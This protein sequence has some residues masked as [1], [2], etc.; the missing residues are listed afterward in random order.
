MH[1]EHMGLDRFAAVRNGSMSVSTGM[2]AT[3]DALLQRGAWS[4]AVQ[5]A[6]I[7]L[8]KPR[9]HAGSYV[10]LPSGSAPAHR[11][12]SAES[13]LARHGWLRLG[14]KNRASTVNV[15]Q[16][17]FFASGVALH[18]TDATLLKHYAR[19]LQSQS[20]L[21]LLLLTTD[22]AP[23]AFDSIDRPLISSMRQHPTFLWTERALQTNCAPLAAAVRNSLQGMAREPISNHARYYYY[24]L[25]YTS[26][27]PRDEVLSRM[28]SS[29]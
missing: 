15:K 6:R 17:V 26:P 18:R 24:C 28:P 4:E 2:L 16:L 20:Q 8:T 3:A 10:S 5:H 13:R 23:P 21:W 1:S 27:S 14:S 11:R 22:E 9:L 19:Q 12:G 25:L 29:A 7:A